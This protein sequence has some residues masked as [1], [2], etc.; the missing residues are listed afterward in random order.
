MIATPL[1]RRRSSALRID[2]AVRGF[3]GETVRMTVSIPTETVESRNWFEGVLGIL[4]H[5]KRAHDDKLRGWVPSPTPGPEDVNWHCWP[6][7]H[8]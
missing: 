5:A 7:N 4:L 8:P 3:D 2:Y 6:G 1:R